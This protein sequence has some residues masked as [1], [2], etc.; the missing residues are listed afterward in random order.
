[1]R[2]SGCVDMN[3]GLGALGNARRRGGGRVTGA[4]SSTSDGVLRARGRKE[5]WHA[6]RP[7]QYLL[8]TAFRYME[9]RKRKEEREEGNQSTLPSFLPSFLPPPS[10]PSHLLRFKCLYPDRARPARRRRLA[11]LATEPEHGGKSHL[12]RKNSSLSKRLRNFDLADANGA[13]ELGFTP[14]LC[15]EAGR[16]PLD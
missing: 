14:S 3:V 4:F 13:L 5:R 1:M 15:S 9:R 12:V 10:F 8:L 6:A 7:S 2:A 11:L 16:Q